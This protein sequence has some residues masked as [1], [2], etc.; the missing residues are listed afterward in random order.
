M[1]QGA[2]E[3]R[4][5][6]ALGGA[7]P[8]KSTIV[9]NQGGRL[10]LRGDAPF[11]VNFGNNLVVNGSATVDVDQI[12][13]TPATPTGDLFLQLGELRLNGAA[14][15]VEGANRRALEF[16]GVTTVTG[17]ATI[18]NSVTVRLGGQLTG[19]GSLTKT[20]AG[21]LTLS[22]IAPNTFADFTRVEGGTLE[23][24]KAPGSNSVPGDLEIRGGTVVL[25]TPGQI[26]DTARVTVGGPGALSA[27]G[28]EAPPTLDLNG[29]SEIIAELNNTNGKL[30][31]NGA[32]S[33][34]GSP[35]PGAGGFSAA[36]DPTVTVLSGGTTTVGG[37]KN[38]SALDT[39]AL[40]VSGGSNLVGVNGTITV[41][42]GGMQFSGD[43]PTLR[44]AADANSPQDEPGRLVLKSDVSSTAA[45]VASVL[46][47]GAAP[48]AG[49]I[50][51]DGGTRRF[52]VANAAATLDLT[53]RVVNGGLQKEGPGVLRLAGAGTYAGGTTLTTGDLEAADPA[54]LG[55]GPVS[56]EGGRLRLRSDAAAVT[57]DND[58]TTAADGNV[59]VDI[60]RLSPGGAAGAFHMKALTLGSRIDVTGAAGGTLVFTGPV[61]LPTAAG[62]PTPTT[63][64]NSAVGLAFDGPVSGVTNLT[65]EGIGTLAFR[66]ASSNSYS[67]LTT[68][69]AGTLEL[70]KS[71][72]AAVPGDLTIN[73][74]GT[75]RLMAS[76]QVVDGATVKLNAATGVAT[77]DLNGRNETIA[78]LSGT[79]TRGRVALGGGTLTVADRLT[80]A[81]GVTLSITGAVAGAAAPEV[82]AGGTSILAALTI[83]GTTGAWAG[84]LDLADTDLVIRDGN[85]ATVTN[86]IKSG[87]NFAAG[88]YWN[89]NGITSSAAAAD[90]ARMKALGVLLNDDGTGQT[91]Y[92]S[93]GGEEIGPG[94]VLVA[95]TIYGDANLD[96]QITGVD[97]ALIDAGFAFG[98][99]D[100][101]GGD[102]DYSGQV[103][104]LDYAWIDASFVVTTGSTAE[105][106]TL[107]AAHAERFGAAYAEAF[108]AIR[109]GT[110]APPAA[111]GAVP[112]PGTG[113]LLLAGAAGLLARRRRRGLPADGR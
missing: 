65:K 28:V 72:G 25:M 93:F 68:V 18:D 21:R 55:T 80:A 8:S 58:A 91:I 82:Q 71:A 51:L 84:R 33:V 4:H 44:L 76:D 112:E 48:D 46:S 49:T 111:P 11:P 43:S 57:F 45:G 12:T 27:A 100:W 99:D 77:L 108:A 88:G 14:L 94:D 104:A 26:A 7:G 105:V 113:G 63:T 97:Y 1:N 96:R 42:V 22:G 74:P 24:A 90:P 101:A 37:G 107:V 54:A 92:G 40:I 79:G 50:D 89:G 15:T 59:R 78:S 5:P 106:A 39:L 85:L 38:G 2:L 13:S 32:L 95:S 64:V 30:T 16:T 81:A 6:G 70:G 10:S 41:G 83:G 98:S 87:A 62:G 47:E 75:V 19:N 110:Y 23:L 67:G 73:G 61:T 17:A 103:D 36:A 86:Q 3:L 34:T 102:F 31:I 52:V 9:L 20:G 35:Q 109:D 29:N 69:N 53:S 66:G 56:F 60:G